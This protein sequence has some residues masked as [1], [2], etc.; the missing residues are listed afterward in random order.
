[1]PRPSSRDRLI[2]AG[3]LA[4]LDHGAARTSVEAICQ[5]VGV[6]KG[7]FFHHF[8]DKDDF[9]AALIPPFAAR[10]AGHLVQAGLEARPT[11]TAHLDAYLALL[12]RIFSRDAWF[13]HGCLYLALAQ[14]YGPES[15]IGKA[16]GQRL[17]DWLVAATRQFEAIAA[18]AGTTPQV[19]VREIAEQL[20]VTV[21][22]GLLVNRTRGRSD[23]VRRALVQFRRYALAVL[24]LEREPGARAG[25]GLG[26]G[27]EAGEAGEGAGRGEGGGGDGGHRGLAT[28]PLGL[29]SVDK[30]ASEAKDTKQYATGRLSD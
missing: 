28:P 18:K 8:Q 25:S 11:A 16:C 24:D 14:E 7:A 15:A 23:G 2:E 1:M 17:D 10:G 13:R 9:I 30:T 29:P 19:G 27:F 22:G 21:E 6:T 12:T 20:L 5:Q 4:V 26:G 3:I